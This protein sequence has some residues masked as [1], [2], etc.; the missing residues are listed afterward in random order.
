[1]KRSKKISKNISYSELERKK[2]KLKLNKLL[3]KTAKSENEV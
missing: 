2:E 1:M 3:V